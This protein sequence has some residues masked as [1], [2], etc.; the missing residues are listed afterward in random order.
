MSLFFISIKGVSDS[1]FGH[2]GFDYI[3]PIGI[4][5]FAVFVSDDFD[6]IT[7][8]D[9]SLQAD[10]LLVNFSAN[11]FVAQITMDMIGEV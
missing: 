2:G 9:L 8:F 6:D 1:V 7:A 3:Q 10:Q 5:I 4:G 11:A